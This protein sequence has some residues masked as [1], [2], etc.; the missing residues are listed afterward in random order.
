MLRPDSSPGAHHAVA[1]ACYVQVGYEDRFAGCQETSL[2]APNLTVKGKARL[3]VKAIPEARI[4]YIKYKDRCFKHWLHT[5]SMRAR[6]YVWPRYT[7]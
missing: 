6:T 5:H 4:A 2:Q 7:W 3:F 1:C